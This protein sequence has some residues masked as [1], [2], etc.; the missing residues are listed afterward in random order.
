MKKM[1]VG[2]A[3]ELERAFPEFVDAMQRNS[4]KT[5]RLEFDD[6]ENEPD[7]LYNCTWYAISYGRNVVIQSSH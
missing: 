4:G 2:T 6:F 5:L 1:P 3:Q 7:L